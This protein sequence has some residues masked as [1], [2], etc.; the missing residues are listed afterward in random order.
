MKAIVYNE[1]GSPDV[2]QLESVQKPTPK[3]NE[4]LVRIRATTVG[5][6]DLLA[7]NFKY[8]RS[9]FNMPSLFWLPARIAF[10]YNRPAQRILGSEFAGEVAAIGKNVTRF[11]VG[12]PVFGYPGASF[13]AYAE[14]LCMREDGLLTIKPA[15]MTDPEAATIPYGALTAL[16]LLRKVAIQPGQRVLINGASG[17]IGAAALQLA[18]HY[19]AEVTGVCGTPRMDFVKALGA[20][21]VIDYTKQDFT[22]NGQ[23]Y[24]LIVDVLGKCSF[25]HCR[26]SLKPEGVLLLASFKARQALRMLWTS[27]TGGKK[28]ICALSSYKPEDLTHIKELV[29]AGQIKAVIDR[30]YPLEQAA[31]AHRYVESGAK[32]ANVVIVMGNSRSSVDFPASG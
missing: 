21:H 6:G 2:L 3:D 25:S 16:S 22:Q 12:D 32:T 5:Y 7:R 28:M 29:E 1:Y 11:K 31:S 30:C 17:S 14:Y 26:D 20:D 9:A 8:S 4:V 15:D 19:G 24:D 13:G 18:K 27:L 10:G 23:T